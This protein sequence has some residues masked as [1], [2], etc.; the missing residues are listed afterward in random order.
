[1]G[2]ALGADIPAAYYWVFVPMVSLL[3]LLPLS[4]NGMGVREGGTV[5]FLAPLGVPA[6]T[7]LTLSFLWFAVHLACSLVGGLIYLL[8][9]V[10]AGATRAETA[11]GQESGHGP[12]DG[13]LDR[14]ADQGRAGQLNRAA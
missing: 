14:G 2:V 1:M 5:L 11:A 4:V 6:A 13:P 8:G 9:V 7:A 10:P 3:T 12:S